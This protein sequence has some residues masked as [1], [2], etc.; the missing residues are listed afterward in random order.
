MVLCYLPLGCEEM[1]KFNYAINRRLRSP[2]WY[3]KQRANRT[4]NPGGYKGGRAGRKAR[5]HP[6]MVKA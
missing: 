3:V 2:A 6:E 5:R 1:T 4:P